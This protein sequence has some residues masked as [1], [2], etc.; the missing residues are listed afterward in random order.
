MRTL[1]FNSAVCTGGHGKYSLSSLGL[2][3]WQH[4][5]R[6]KFARTPHSSGSYWL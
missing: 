5:Y 1:K 6:K 2:L 3:W 4:I